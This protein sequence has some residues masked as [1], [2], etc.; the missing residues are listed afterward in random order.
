MK[1]EKTGKK[2]LVKKR[3]KKVAGRT[4][5][6]SSDSLSL[7]V[8]NTQ[9]KEVEQIKLSG[10]VFD[11]KVSEALIRQAVVTYLSNQR[12]GLASSKTRGEVSGGGTKPWRQKGTGRAR[13]GSIRSPL[14]RGG[15]VT[16]GPKPRS[17]YRDLP[18]KMR[19]AA[20]KSALNAKL[21]DKEIVILS[22]LKVNSHK[23]KDFFKIIRG[24]K[25]DRVKV[26]LVVEKLEPNIKLATANI[27]EV[28][29]AK[30]SDVH[31]IQIVDC[32]RLVL[33]K[34]ALRNLEERVKK[35]LS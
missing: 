14:W 3:A 26:R 6:S 5:V 34:S 35:C 29:M 23:T 18:K 16:F 28:L 22:D 8:L 7:P 31:T 10:Q 11:G 1:A 25:L 32:K 4:K 13:V 19:S 15:G 17:Y 33:T 2:R 24:L 21:R 9:G 30:A 20:L 12:K 27:K